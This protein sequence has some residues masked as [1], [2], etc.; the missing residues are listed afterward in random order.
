MALK[1]KSFKYVQR[2][3]RMELKQAHRENSALG[4]DTG[5]VPRERAT[6]RI[7]LLEELCREFD[8]NLVSMV[9]C[10]RPGCGV[11]FPYLGSGR[12]YCSDACR[13]AAYRIRHGYMRI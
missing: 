5:I 11:P 4:S 7:D 12:K 8:V 3:L 6:T 13:Q 1:K 9:Q 2:H 10:K